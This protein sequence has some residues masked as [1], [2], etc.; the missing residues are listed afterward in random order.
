MHM[1]KT[2]EDFDYISGNCTR[3]I[4]NPKC[5]KK[6]YGEWCCSAWEEYRMQCV[7]INLELSCRPHTDDAA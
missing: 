2:D 4:N 6:C 1:C 7:I 3:R 5:L